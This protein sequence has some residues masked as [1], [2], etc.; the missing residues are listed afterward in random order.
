MQRFERVAPAQPVMLFRIGVAYEV[1]GKRDQALIALERAMKAGY[2]EKEV[3]G[4]PELLN[5]RNDIRYHKIVASLAAPDR[6]SK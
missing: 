5:L 2:A 3:R 1:C 4:E 6:L